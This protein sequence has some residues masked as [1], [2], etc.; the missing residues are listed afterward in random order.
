MNV[1]KALSGI[2]KILGKITDFMI[3]GRKAG[4]WDKR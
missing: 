2:R 1:L 4:W 3:K